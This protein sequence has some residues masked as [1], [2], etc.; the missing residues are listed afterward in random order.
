[1]QITSADPACG[2]SPWASAYGDH[3]VSEMLYLHDP[4]Q[5]G[6]ELSREARRLRSAG[7]R[8]T[9]PVAG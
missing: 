8:D 9:A 4:D 7:R 6:V 2:R 3:G 1:M 5:N